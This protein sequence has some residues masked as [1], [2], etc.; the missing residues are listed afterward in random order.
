MKKVI[1]GLCSRDYYNRK[2]FEKVAS[3]HKSKLLHLTG[4]DNAEY[5]GVEVKLEEGKATFEGIVK[6]RSTYL[7]LIPSC[8]YKRDPKL[9]ELEVKVE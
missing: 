3:L 9:F 1:I 4:K 8:L 6:A 7:K 2:V 5:I